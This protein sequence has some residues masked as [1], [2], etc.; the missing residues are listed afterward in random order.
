M[1]N[2]F[3]RHFLS[4][5][6]TRIS[7]QWVAVGQYIPP[8]SPSPPKANAAY[9]ILFA[10]SLM[11][12]PVD[13]KAC[14]VLKGFQNTLLKTNKKLLLRLHWDPAYPGL[15]FQKNDLFFLTYPPFNHQFFR[16][17]VVKPLE[18]KTT[19]LGSRS[20]RNYHLNILLMEE[21]L[22]RL[23]WWIPHYLQGVMYKKKLA[24]KW[25]A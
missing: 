23:V 10:N 6:L 3:W 2:C 12:I 16:G 11:I 24:L 15:C 25:R 14:L 7:D 19:T 20:H 22:H 8:I 21:I 17:Y 13:L 1:R 4:T 5:V 18:G 9:T